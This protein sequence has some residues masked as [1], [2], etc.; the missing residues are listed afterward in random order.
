[1]HRPLIELADVIR[2]ATDRLLDRR[3]FAREVGFVGG[4][5]SLNNFSIDRKLRAGFHEQSHSR[6]NAFELHFPFAALFIQ[7]RGE[8]WRVAE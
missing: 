3:G 8:F 6:T 4:G 5:L 2:A 1:M 7:N